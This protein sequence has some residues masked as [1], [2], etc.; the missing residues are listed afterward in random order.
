[1]RQYLHIHLSDQRVE[2][3]TIEGEA[4]VNCGRH[5]IAET[6]LNAGVASIDPLSAE[7]PLI[8][9]AGPLA[10]SN[11]SNANRLSVGCKS[12]LTGGIKEANAGGT[13]AFNLGQLHLAGLTLHGVS[14]AWQLIV[15]DKEQNV[16]FESA[17]DLLGKGNFEVAEQL[18]ERFGKKVSL[19]ICSPVGE[20]GG[21]MAGIAFSDTDQRPTRLAARGGVGA[22]MGSKRIKAIVVE[23]LKMPTFHDR[24]KVLGAVKS[25]M[26]LLREDPTIKA[27]ADLGTAMV[28]DF[29]NEVGGIPVRNFSA[30]RQEPGESQPFKLGGQHLR[31][32]NLSRGGETTH[33]CMPGCQIKCSNVFA[34]ADGNELV[35][36]MEYETIGLMGTN[37]GLSEPDELARVN[38]LANDLGVDTI[39]AGATLAVLM[40]AGV[41]EFGD[42]DFM[43]RVLDE[44]IRKGTEQGKLWASGTGRVGA[45]YGLARTPVIKN[46]A[47]SA[48]DPRVIEVTG[49]TMMMT[50]QGADHTAGN[51]PTYEC[52]DKPIDELVAASVESQA[53]CAAAD[54]LGLCIFGRSVTNTQLEFMVETLNGA[55]GLDLSNEFYVNLGRRTLRLEQ[56]FNRA[57]GFT[58]EDDEL[59]SFFYEEALAPSQRTARF[60]A[61]EVDQSPARWA[62]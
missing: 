24:K 44:D 15:I 30:G 48:Y 43:C 3:D 17:D 19:A 61:Q 5:F 7:N 6:L 57:A 27:F 18:H 62:D 11:F 38:W 8:F 14:D 58:V 33:A 36:P 34:D 29:T 1:M 35:S 25:Y 21:L 31:E 13:F 47:I 26:G 23:S 49:L 37:C 60:H 12:P 45:H 52:F 59:P 56:D 46:Q 2:R 50:A 55:F 9:S 16:R 53:L 41:A 39:E 28:G 10:G 22:V 40:D 32:L 42:V 20:Y 51:L 54:S 4:L